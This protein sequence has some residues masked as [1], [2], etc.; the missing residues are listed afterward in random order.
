MTGAFAGKEV[1]VTGGSGGIGSAV[2][3]GLAAEGAT[4]TIADRDERGRELAAQLGGRFVAVDLTD[5]E[6]AVATVSAAV[7]RLDGLVNVAGIAESKRFPEVG[8]GDWEV[9][10]RVNAIAPYLLIQALADRISDGGAVVSITSLE[11]R[12]PVGVVGPM[13]SIYAASKA[14][15]GSLA[16]S[17]A[18]VLGER[19]IRINSVAPG[20]VDTPLADSVRELGEGWTSAQTPLG[21]WAQPSE[22]ADAVLFLLSDE[23]TY[24][25]G[26]SLRVDGG[27]AMGPQRDIR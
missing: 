9:V 14:A 5:P 7:E 23:S 1:L 18:P 10:M 24:V 20:F 25:T 17:L 12:L 6:A 19:R 11:E 21:R 16:R 13:T 2:A 15:L 8:V 22:V 27:V 26:T 4:V 3:T